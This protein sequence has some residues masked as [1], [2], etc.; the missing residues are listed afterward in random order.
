MADLLARRAAGEELSEQEQRTL[1]SF[2]REIA[3]A[4]PVGSSP[5]QRIVQE[6]V[7][8]YLAGRR[9]A[10]AERLV[11]LSQKTRDEIVRALEGGD[12]PRP[13]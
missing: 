11:A 7:A 13:V 8:T 3:R 12:A 9:R 2:E 6:A 1:R 5:V 4:L 10:S